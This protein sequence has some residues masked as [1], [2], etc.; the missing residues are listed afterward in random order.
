MTSTLLELAVSSLAFRITNMSAVQTITMPT[1]P[2]IQYHPE[3]ET[4][5]SRFSTSFPSQ[6]SGDTNFSGK[7]SGKVDCRVS[8]S[9]LL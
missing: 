3:Y 5:S 9:T 1:Q 4:Q 7:F 2:D 6:T 8:V